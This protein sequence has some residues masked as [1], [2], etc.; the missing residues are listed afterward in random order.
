M[1]LLMPNALHQFAVER[2]LIELGPGAKTKKF[3]KSLA[4]ALSGEI[5]AEGCGCDP[6]EPAGY[7]REQCHADTLKDQYESLKKFCNLIPDAYRLRHADC[8]VDVIE[9]D[10][11]STLA[12][13]IGRYSELAWE[14]DASA[15][16]QLRLRLYNEHF[17]KIGEY[18][19][20]QLTVLSLPNG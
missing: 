3:I 4:E 16:W 19:E 2:A 1:E 20:G 8:L 10:G 5:C 15:D 11:S 12:P 13:K 6:E 7:T 17:Q 18:D 9:I 14:I